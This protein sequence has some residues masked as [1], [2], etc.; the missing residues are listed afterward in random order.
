MKQGLSSSTKYYKYF[1]CIKIYYFL[2]SHT[3]FWRL[4][5]TSFFGAFDVLNLE[6]VGRR[7]LILESN[8]SSSFEELM[9]TVH[10]MTVTTLRNHSILY[11]V[12]IKIRIFDDD[13]IKIWSKT[14]SSRE[15]KRRL[16][17]Y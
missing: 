3:L 10:V 4:D 13:S 1:V 15:I 9:L 2:D 16:A 14:H 7:N 17:Q 5:S 12:F 8:P 11:S 6:A